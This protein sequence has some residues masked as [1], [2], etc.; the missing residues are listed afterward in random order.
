MAYS[1]RPFL[2]HAASQ[3]TEES[4]PILLVLVDGLLS[5]PPYLVL[6]FGQ[7]IDLTAAMPYL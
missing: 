1:V 7:C 3:Q 2:A 5:A 4:L 6:D